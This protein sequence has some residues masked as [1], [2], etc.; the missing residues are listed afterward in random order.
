MVACGP[1]RQPRPIFTWRRNS[2]L[3]VITPA[4]LGSLPI[5]VNG[6]ISVPSPISARSLITTW[7]LIVTSSPMTTS[8]PITQ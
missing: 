5:S 1:S 7:A 4:A 6:K 2:T 3:R 8:L